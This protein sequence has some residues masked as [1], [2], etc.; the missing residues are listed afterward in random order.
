MLSITDG[1]KE[2]LTTQITNQNSKYVRLG[3]YG[4]GCSGFQY[5]WDFVNEIDD[6]TLIEN[7]LVLD[8]MSEMYVIGCTVDW[9]NEL[10][11]AYLKVV[12]PNA[13]ASCGCGESFAV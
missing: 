4:G 5:K 7:M 11:G 8:K 12:N 6:G 1:A 9:V 13:V 2:Y 10:G 3:V